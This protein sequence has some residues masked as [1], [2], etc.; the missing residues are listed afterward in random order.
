MSEDDKG[1][2]SLPELIAAYR[3]A[4]AR[5]AQPHDGL[6]RCVL[7]INAAANLLRTLGR[8]I[9]DTGSGGEKAL[10][11]IASGDNSL[12][13]VWAAHHILELSSPSAAAEG[14]AIAVIERAASGDTANA[15]GEQ[16]WLNEWRSR[17]R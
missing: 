14:L 5:H 11:E 10:M 3:S 16:L 12:A 2:Q 15:F 4:A 7:E 1:R 8:T 17:R 9:L 6:E 13:A